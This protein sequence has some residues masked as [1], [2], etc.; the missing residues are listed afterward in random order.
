MKT[1]ALIEREIHVARTIRS[2][3]ESRDA[4]SQE[5][6][7]LIDIVGDDISL[8]WY[9]VGIPVTVCAYNSV[10]EP[11]NMT[12][13]HF[14]LGVV[15]LAHIPF[16]VDVGVRDELSCRV[17]RRRKL[18]LPLAGRRR[19]HRERMGIV[20]VGSGIVRFIRVGA[21]VSNAH[22]RATPCGQDARGRTATAPE[23]THLS[24]PFLPSAASIPPTSVIS[25]LFRLSIVTL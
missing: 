15:P 13:N 9:A 8:L 21:G 18:R 14:V 5:V 2:S 4:W 6:R 11:G 10:V 3:G 19:H 17:A 23:N 20:E 16:C 12:L 24:P 7:R 1:V 22:D 25:Q